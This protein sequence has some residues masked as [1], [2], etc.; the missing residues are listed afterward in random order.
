MLPLSQSIPPDGEPRK[1][2]S[3]CPPNPRQFKCREH[4][5]SSRRLGP[6][7]RRGD[8]RA[9]HAAPKWHLGIWHKKDCSPQGHLPL[10]TTPHATPV[11]RR[12]LSSS[13][14]IRNPAL[15]PE[16]RG[17]QE[18]GNPRW[19]AEEEHKDTH[20]PGKQI[21]TQ[22]PTCTRITQTH[23]PSPGPETWEDRFVIRVIL[24]HALTLFYLATEWVEMLCAPLPADSKSAQGQ[25]YLIMT[26]G[27]S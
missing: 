26:P 19:R 2:L 17:P 3:L 18:R 10:A 20:R 12:H 23:R 8:S 6:C 13:L 15:F 16:D 1:F 9:A 21:H 4:G 11:Q 5:G 14:E 27:G 24:L 25:R 7:L 22:R